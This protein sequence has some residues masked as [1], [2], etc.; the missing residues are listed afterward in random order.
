MTFKAHLFSL[1]ANC[2]F[3]A[4]KE[5]KK[6]RNPCKNPSGTQVRVRGAQPPQCSSRSVLAGTDDGGLFV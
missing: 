5:R 2:G 4:K 6:D 3:D 1:G